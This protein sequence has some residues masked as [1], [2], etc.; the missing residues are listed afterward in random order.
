[1]NCPLATSRLFMGTLHHVQRRSGRSEER[2]CDP[3]VMACA[4]SMSVQNVVNQPRSD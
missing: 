2:A 1:M 4:F 3:A